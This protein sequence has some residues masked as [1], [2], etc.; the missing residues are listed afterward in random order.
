MPVFVNGVE[1]S[2]GLS[3]PLSANLDLSSNL[4]VGNG[5]STGIAISSAGEVT[6]AAQPAV[7]AYNSA[8]DDNVTGDGT[9]ATIDFDTELFDQNADF[10]SDVFTA[11]VTGRYL[12]T[13]QVLLDGVTS[14]ETN[15]LLDFN[16]SN[17][18]WEIQHAAYTNVTS[19]ARTTVTMVAIIDM[20][21]LDTVSIRVS[22]NGGTKIVDV[23]GEANPNTNITV[24]LL[25]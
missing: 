10:A 3:S 6:L 8:D 7:A 5:G 18:T 22:I 19:G 16:S 12:V 14:A 20:D 24:M 25:A 13:A 17:R 9:Y 15:A 11:P 1:Q 2:S 21:A 23:N 4:L